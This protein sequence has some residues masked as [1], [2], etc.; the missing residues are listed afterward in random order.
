MPEPTAQ[1]RTP[2]DVKWLLNERAALLGQVAK[3][4]AL[5][6]NLAAK[7]CRLEKQ[8]TG[9]QLLVKRS[10]CAQSRA[11]ASIEAL[12]ATMAMTHALVIPSAAGTVQAW[13]GKYGTRGGLRDFIA[14]VLE[15][16][17]PEPVTTKV[18]MDLAAVRFELE[19]RTHLER[20]NFNKSVSSALTGLHKRKLIEPSHARTQGSHGLWRWGT[21]AP[22]VAKLANAEAS[23]ARS[24]GS[25]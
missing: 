8:L 10:E 16:A 20:R 14:E 24:Q 19:L 23:Q 11:Q 21:T 25:G 2:P 17:S 9:V 13:A 3:A 6:E 15:G 18:L 22:S 12:D 4:R 5:Q 1:T 7:Q